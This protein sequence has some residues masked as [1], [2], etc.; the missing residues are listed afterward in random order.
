MKIAI[1]PGSFDPV[2]KGHMDIIT[3]AA[4]LFDR[5]I[6]LVASNVM[7]RDCL[8]SAG[9]RIELLRRCCGGMPNV[10]VD[11]DE[12][13][14]AEY[15]RRVGATAIVKG[16]RAM[17]DF[18]YE[19]QQALTNRQLNSRVE[20]IFLAASGESMYLSSSMVKQVCALGGD[21]SSFVPP[22]ALP[23][24]LSRMRG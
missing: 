13:L 23:E 17:S 2:T 12:G 22:E 7:K 9:E 18:D 20:T 8:F 10:T 11:C 21:V 19:F 4:A 16:L 15:A 3:R 14:I 5:L 1:Y 24:I 6:V